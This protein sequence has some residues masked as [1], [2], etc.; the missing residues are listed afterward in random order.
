MRVLL[1]TTAG[2]GHLRPMLPFAASC[3]RAGHE[4]RVA[5]PRSFATQVEAAGYPYLACD[6]V[7]VERM[8]ELRAEAARLPAAEHGR[9]ALRLFGELGPAAMRPGVLAAID[10]YRPDLILRDAAELGSFLAARTRSVPQAQIFSTVRRSADAAMNACARLLAQAGLSPATPDET[11]GQLHAVPALSLLPESLDPPESAEPPEAV[12]RFRA[13]PAVPTLVRA[14]DTQLPLIYVSFGAMAPAVP[15]TTEALHT[16][17]AA[18]AELPVRLLV[19]I[20]RDADPADWAGYGPDVRVQSWVDEPQ[21]VRQA[22][23]VVCHGG[24]GTTLGALTAGA[25]VV[26]VPQFGDQPDIGAAVEATGAGLMVRDAGY[27]A[28]VRRL[29]AEPEFRDRARGLADE[30]AT[31]PTTDQA[32]TLLAGIASGPGAA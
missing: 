24:A 11:A 20:G 1:V 10:D 28:A 14:D 29:L 31:L 5:A 25:P 26:V 4:V 7:A 32:V 3:E 16:T 22:A 15:G 21:V 17:V 13:P 18:L 9:L 23:A 2:A 8:A 27:G 30:I 12:H 19:S 6:D